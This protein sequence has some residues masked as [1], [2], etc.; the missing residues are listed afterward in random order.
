VIDQSIN[1]NGLKL[2]TAP[3]FMTIHTMTPCIRTYKGQKNSHLMYFKAAHINGDQG[4]NIKAEFLV[5]LMYV[6]VARS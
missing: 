6:H 4:S 5:D 1:Q 3:I 2:S